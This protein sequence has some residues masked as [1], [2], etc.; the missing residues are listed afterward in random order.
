MEDK[1]EIGSE[2]VW[3]RYKI[4]SEYAKVFT[5][6]NTDMQHSQKYFSDILEKTKEVITKYLAQ[7]KDE[8]K[9]QL[10]E[11]FKRILTESFERDKTFNEIYQETLRDLLLKIQAQI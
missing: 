7:S 6:I 9:R 8:Q 4:S 10:N 11:K 3:K 1:S 5:L 2:E